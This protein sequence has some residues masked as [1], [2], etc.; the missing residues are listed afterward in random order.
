MPFLAVADSGF[1]SIIRIDPVVVNPE[2][3]HVL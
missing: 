3:V 2:G 1:M